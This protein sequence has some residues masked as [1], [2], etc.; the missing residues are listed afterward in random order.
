MVENQSSWKLKC[1]QSDN[2]G[3]FIRIF[4]QCSIRLEL[5]TPYSPVPNGV[6]ERMNRKIQ[7][8]IVTMMQHARLLNGFWEEMLFTILHIIN[9]SP[10]RSL[11][12]PIP[13]E[14]WTSR[15][16][17]YEKM[18]IFSCGAVTLVLKDYRKNLEPRSRRCIFLDY[19]STVN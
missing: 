11:G 9:M 6:A 5:T 13:H 8:W 1:S 15:R 2:G 17:N 18:R 10:S 19:G 14:L 16:L 4:R 7:E 3:E 12:L